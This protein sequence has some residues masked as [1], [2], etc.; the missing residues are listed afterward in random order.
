LLLQ[1]DIDTLKKATSIRITLMKLFASTLALFVLSSVYASDLV[2]SSCAKTLLTQ[3][4]ECIKARK[5]TEGIALYIQVRDHPNAE[6]CMIIKA[7]AEL[8][9]H[10]QQN[11]AIIGFKRTIARADI[12]ESQLI[13]VGIILRDM[14]AIDEANSAFKK[15][16]AQPIVSKATRQYIK[17]LLQP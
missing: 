5:P 14:G 6:V 10:Q 12:S 3:A 1:K 2:L 8:K 16:L 7:S 9:S 13:H 4:F 17:G 11:D 15:V